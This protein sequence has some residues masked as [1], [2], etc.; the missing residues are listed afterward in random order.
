M[1]HGLSIDVEDYYQVIYRDF[2]Q[3]RVPPSPEVERNTQWVLETLATKKVRATF[4]VLSNVARRYPE[5]ITRIVKE[6]HEIAV[7]GSDH[8]YIYLMKPAEFKAEIRHAKQEIEDISGSMAVGHRAPAFSITKETFWAIDILQEIGF[9]Y[10]SSIYPVQTKRYGIKE[11]EK[12]IYRWPN[13]LYEIP[14]SCL[15][16]LGRTVPVAGGGYIRHFPFWWTR[17]AIKRLEQLNR[18][19]IV[20]MHPYEFE[21]SYPRLANY[22]ENN[23]SLKLM[24]HTLLQGHNRGKKQRKKLNLLLAEFT[25]VPLRELIARHGA[26]NNSGEIFLHG[27]TR[28][29]SSC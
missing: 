5:L 15:E 17:Y 3:H 9:V 20:Y 2:F 29:T 1:M 19:A 23:M 12:S 18:Q 24:I 22:G 26:K 11:A 10:D 8:T 21:E 14:L 27:N 28:G 25:F 7:H 16:C 13:G 6:G 4:F